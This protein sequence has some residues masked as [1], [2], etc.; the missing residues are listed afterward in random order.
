MVSCSVYDKKVGLPYAD[1]T[2][3]IFNHL[4]N[5]QPKQQTEPEQRR[6]AAVI[7][8]EETQTAISD[9]LLSDSHSPGSRPWAVSGSLLVWLTGLARERLT[10]LYMPSNC[11]LGTNEVLIDWLIYIYI[12]FICFSCIS[13]VVTLYLFGLCIYRHT[14]YSLWVFVM[15]FKQYLNIL[16]RVPAKSLR[17]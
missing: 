7:P 9:S 1:N 13:V 2:T 4:W 17:S 15:S 11:S 8:R 12:Y 10:L 14:Y 5:S 6:A 3:K 16:R